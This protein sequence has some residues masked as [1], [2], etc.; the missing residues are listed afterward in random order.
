MI[1][2]SELI[3]YKDGN[4]IPLLQAGPTMLDFGFIHSDSTYDVMPVYNGRAFCYER[5]VARFRKSAARYGLEL[6]DVDFLEIIKT[7]IEKNSSSEIYMHRSGR[8][9]ERPQLENAFVWFAAWRGYPPSGN[10]RDIAN[11][12]VHFA[13]YIK[14][15]YP[16]VNKDTISVY[17]D[18]TAYRV[19]DRYFGQE[20]KNM[21]WIDLTMAQRNVPEGYDTCVLVDDNGFIA[22]GPG[23]NVGFVNSGAIIT[24]KNNCLKGITMTVVEDIAKENNIGFLRSDT[25]ADAWEDMDEIFLTSSSGG[26]TPVKSGPITEL[27]VKEYE[28]KKAEPGYAT[29]L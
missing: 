15:S 13:M 10:P 26:V 12:P 19:N 27:L 21:S 2:V 29:D 18:R 1:S 28:K 6:P 8:L 14:P 22:E 24:P 16:L 7:L 25:S 9:A 23:F 17:L 4:Y 20:Y 5:H 3:A 11:A